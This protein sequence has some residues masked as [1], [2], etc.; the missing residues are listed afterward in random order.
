[1][2]L[3]SLSAFTKFLTTVGLAA[4]VCLIVT[5]SGHALNWN[6][7]KQK[8]FNILG[9]QGAT[10]KQKHSSQAFVTLNNMNGFVANTMFG[11]LKNQL[12]V[13]QLA[14]QA[15]NNS[16]KAKNIR[17]QLNGITTLGEG[18][19]ATPNNIGT[20]PKYEHVR[21]SFTA[22]DKT[23]N[24]PLK[25]KDAGRSLE[26]LAVRLNPGAS[27]ENIVTT[28][29]MDGSINKNELNSFISN[30]ASHHKI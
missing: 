25:G 15:L 6:S 22:L 2:F 5:S 28:Y 3:F 26:V 14:Q 7:L 24:K 18:A 23:T 1:M 30:L 8:P 12:I 21:A 16:K 9:Q 4:I 13:Q 10:Y 27:S 29:N 11:N 19:Y 20:R 17:L